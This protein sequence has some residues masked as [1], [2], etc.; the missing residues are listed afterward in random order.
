MKI[1]KGFKDIRKLASDRGK[2]IASCRSCISY[3]YCEVE[4][5]ER[6]MNNEVTEFDMV[7]EE[8]REFCTFWRCERRDE[9]E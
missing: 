9:N 7:V 2:Y 6:C 4:K 8:T 3:G 1:K 5:I